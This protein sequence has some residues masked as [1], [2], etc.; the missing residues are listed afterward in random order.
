VSFFKST[1]DDKVPALVREYLAADA[2]DSA[3]DLSLA[4]W[5][6]VENI[7][8]REYEEFVSPFPAPFLAVSPRAL[9]DR[10]QLGMEAFATYSVD[11]TVL[12]PKQTAAT[13]ALARPAAPA[14]SVGS[15]G[16]LTGAFRY[17]LTG[18][19]AT[20]ESYASNLSTAVT[21][22]AQKG[23]V[24]I[25]SLGSFDGF[26]LW[27][28]RANRTSP[29]F[30]DVVYAPGVYVDNWPDSALGDEAAPD[31]LGAI[32]LFSRI[33]RVVVREGAETLR[34]IL[35]GGGG[36]SIAQ[37]TTTLADVSDKVSAERNQR[38]K[39]MRVTYEIRYRMTDRQSTLG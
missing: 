28:T 3:D 30:L 8:L 15:A 29:Q 19:T 14:V 20:A 38:E 7:E 27:R 2:T 6:G 35:S 16:L 13:T 23:E 26:R 32:K 9:I 1:V 39:V 5:F 12:L 4:G 22:T 18:F 31:T 36:V 17:A 21:L 37:A 10:R 34:N 11:L 33:R 25:P 24:T